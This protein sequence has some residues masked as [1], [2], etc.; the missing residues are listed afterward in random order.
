MYGSVSGNKVYQAAVA[1]PLRPADIFHGHVLFV[2]LR[3]AMNC[4]IF[5]AVAAA[6][7]AVPPRG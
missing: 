4:A 7:G 3:L 5:L 1:S 6:F 2:T